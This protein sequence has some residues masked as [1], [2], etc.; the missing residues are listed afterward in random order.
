M[1]N[2][3]LNLTTTPSMPYTIYVNVDEE[4]EGRSG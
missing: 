3:N 2:W 4:V 1:K